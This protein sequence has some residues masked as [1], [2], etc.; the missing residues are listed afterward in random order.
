M[1]LLNHKPVGEHDL[2]YGLGIYKYI[3]VSE[4]LLPGAWGWEE[5]HT[6]PENSLQAS[7]LCFSGTNCSNSTYPQTLPSCDVRAQFTSSSVRILLPR[8][9]VR[10]TWGSSSRSGI[11]S[12][13]PPSTKC[14]CDSTGAGPERQRRHSQSEQ[15]VF[16]A[17][18]AGAGSVLADEQR[19]G[20]DPEPAP[21]NSLVSV[22]GK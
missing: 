2:L 20:R 3:W 5:K 10:R 18:E 16:G 6:L 8:W 7:F 14:P 13:A 15:P 22:G 4:S 19:E 9:N 12:R 11:I 21:N 17:I 1:V